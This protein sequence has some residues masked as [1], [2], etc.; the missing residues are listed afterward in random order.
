MEWM[1]P[2]RSDFPVLSVHCRNHDASV[3]AQTQ[4]RGDGSE[5]SA[6]RSDDRRRRPSPQ[7]ISLLLVGKD[8]RR[9]QSI[10]LAARRLARRTSPL[11]R[12]AATD[13]HCLHARCTTDAANDAAPTDR[14][15]LLDS[16]RLLDRDDAHPCSG[17][18][19]DW[20]VSARSA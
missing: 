9:R 15:H 1:D 7:C 19:D 18:G 13:R 12:R 6:P 4:S 11:R 20:R 16:D 8:S 10:D 5:D 17:D 3:P 14:H 2:D